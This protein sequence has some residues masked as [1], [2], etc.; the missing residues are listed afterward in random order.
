MDVGRL[1]FIA[2]IKLDYTEKEAWRLT[3][4]KLLI[5]FRE[6]K[7]DNGYEEKEK[8]IDDVIPF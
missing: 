3:L 7:K 5:L 6:W 1:L 4:G 8:T 2:K